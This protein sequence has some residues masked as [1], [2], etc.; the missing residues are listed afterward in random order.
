MNVRTLILPDFEK[1]EE[2]RT[3]TDRCPEFAM[4]T[5]LMQEFAR[6]EGML[7]GYP[8]KWYI[9]SLAL[10]D[11]TDQIPTSSMEMAKNYLRKR[12]RLEELQSRQYDTGVTGVPQPCT[13]EEKALHYF[14][15]RTIEIFGAFQQNGFVR[16][17][18]T[19][20]MLRPT[21][22]MTCH[23]VPLFPRQEY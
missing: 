1:I 13:I 5:P 20:D 19:L 4:D 22:R 3:H 14:A 17:E 2:T 23:D 15:M 8:P 6:L 10:L 11:R 7:G 18:V 16:P 12:I 21:K 9:A